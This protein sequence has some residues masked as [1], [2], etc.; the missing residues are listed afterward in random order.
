MNTEVIENIELIAVRV[1]PGDNWRLV[2]KEGGTEGPTFPSLTD[3]LEN[4]F[5][6]TGDIVDFRL[7]P[8]KSKLYAIRQEEIEINQN[9]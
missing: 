6:K 2:N 7:E 1:P 5:Q 3:T 8:L 9:Q 4:W